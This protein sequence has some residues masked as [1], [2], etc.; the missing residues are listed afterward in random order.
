LQTNEFNDYRDYGVNTYTHT[1]THD[2]C[3]HVEV[4]SL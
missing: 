3:L 4:A 2:C 1:H